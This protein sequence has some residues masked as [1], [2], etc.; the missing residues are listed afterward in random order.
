[1][2]P[3][4]GGLGSRP[5]TLE[6]EAGKT[7]RVGRSPRADVAVPDDPALSSLHFVIECDAR[8]CRLRDLRSSNGTFVNGKRTAEARLRDGDRIRAGSTDFVVRMAA[9][10]DLIEVLRGQEQPLYALLD[11]ARDPRVL[12]L[13]RERDDEHQSLYEGE[14]SEA[15][16]EA[17]PYLVRLPKRSRLLEALVKECWGKSWG[18]YLTSAAPFAEVRKHFRHFLMVKTEDGKDY[19]FRFYD[20]RVLRVFLPVCTKEEVEQ[21]FVTFLGLVPNRLS[22]TCWGVRTQGAR[23][24]TAATVA[25]FLRLAF[26][27]LVRR[28]ERRNGPEGVCRIDP[29]G[30]VTRLLARPEIQRPN[31]IVV[32][33]DGRTLY[34]IESNFLSRAQ[35]RRHDRRRGGQYLRRRRIAPPA[36]HQRD[37]GHPV[38]Y[39]RDLAAGKTHPLHP[40][41]RGHHH[42]LRIRRPGHE[43]LVRHR[44]QD[45]V[46]STDQDRR[47][48]ALGGAMSPL[49]QLWEEHTA[50]EF[51][52]RDTEA[53][54]NTMAEDA[55]VNHVPVM[56][57]GR[58]KPELR[59]FYSRDFIPCMPPD[60]TLTPVS[61]TVG[62]DQLVDEIIFSFTHTQE[63]PWMLPGVPPT[64]RRVEIPLVV[65]VHFREGKLAH[66]HIYW[67][68]AS[69]LKQ[70]GLLT[71]PGLPVRGVETAR[72]VVEGGRSKRT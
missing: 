43:D 53:T 14:E 72:K 19:Y 47:N 1:M 68:Q 69:V 29:D 42:Q 60:T 15:L 56:T 57:G 31:G 10:R 54:L 50:H 41:P 13:L 38:R 23:V 48:A 59:E 18:V 8:G 66:E 27:P 40:H 67:D 71:D 28:A 21:F 64:H 36:R 44:G 7:C 70:I 20:P 49:A 30:K 11:A 58:G 65:I 22:T 63:M 34:L 32:S 35:R 55:Y 24:N 61:R 52:T 17:A 33:P 51:S 39:P 6:M 4:E 26:C 46:Q 3:V 9:A 2:K 25:I 5:I 62:E 16:A 37:A 12:E 45:P